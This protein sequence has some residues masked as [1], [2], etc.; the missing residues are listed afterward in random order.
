MQKKFAR[1]GIDVKLKKSGSVNPVIMVKQFSNIMNEIKSLHDDQE[2]L[3]YSNKRH[4]ALLR[5]MHASV[6]A[7]AIRKDLRKMKPIPKL[8]LCD[9]CRWQNA[10]KNVKTTT[11]NTGRKSTGRL[12]S[13]L[14]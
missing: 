14:H 10:V 6:S 9:Q 13:S 4:K 8:Q 11:Q 12:I 1:E 3:Q 7:P 5:N 2:K